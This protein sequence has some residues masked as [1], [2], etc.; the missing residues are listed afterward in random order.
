MRFVK[1]VHSK[2]GGGRSVLTTE[3]AA[4]HTEDFS[5][6]S[7]ISVISRMCIA[8]VG[9]LSNV[10]FLSNEPEGNAQGRTKTTEDV[11]Y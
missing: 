7:R 6:F 1:S 2:Y 3:M 5:T 8:N 11:L 4:L 9:Y 10:R